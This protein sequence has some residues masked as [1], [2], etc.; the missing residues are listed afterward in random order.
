MT[1]AQG[2][3]AAR[4]GLESSTSAIAATGG[5]RVLSGRGEQRQGAAGR[6]SGYRVRSAPRRQA[7]TA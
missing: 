1:E 2:A 4:A 7:E 5:G 3:S 6:A